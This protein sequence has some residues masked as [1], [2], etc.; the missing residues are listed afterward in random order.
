MRSWPCRIPARPPSSPTSSPIRGASSIPLIA[1]TGGGGSTLAEAAD[2]VLL[3]PA[4]AEA[5]PMGL[6]P[7]TSTTMMMALGDALAIAL[8][9]RRGFSSADFRV[10][11][12]GGRLG[13]RLLRVGRHHARRRRHA[14]G[15]ARGADVRGDPGDDR[16]E[17]RLRR[18]LRRRRAA[19]RRHH[20]WRSAP[21]HGRCAAGPHGGGDHASHAADDRRR[22]TRRRGAWG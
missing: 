8:L 19:G 7:T 15:L 18:R 22:G 16:E 1:M 9:E 21:A 13:R 14:A 20:R 12:P 11:H 17:L 3:L 4:A 5:C 6:A 10:L 2:V